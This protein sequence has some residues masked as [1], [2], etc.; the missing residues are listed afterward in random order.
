M[1]VDLQVDDY[2][3]R[4]DAEEA[5]ERKLQKLEKRLMRY[6][7]EA[8]GL[9][10]KVEKNRKRNLYRCLLELSVPGKSLVAKKELHDQRA[11]VEEAFDALMKEFSKY[12]LKANKNLYGK[13]KRPAVSYSV[14][15]ERI[16]DRELLFKEAL[17]DRLHGL[18]RLAR[19]ELLNY[20]LTG[21][22][23]PGQVLP[24]EIVDEAIVNVYQRL[25]SKT[26]RE[27]ERELMREV[28][29]VAR[30]YAREAR[31]RKGRFVPIEKET[32]PLPIEEEVVTL[33]EEI[34]YFWEPDETVKVEDEIPDP[35]AVTPEQVLEEEELQ[36][37]LYRMLSTLPEDQRTAFTL[38][39]IEC[40]TGEEVA[41]I[42]EKSPEEIAQLV[43]RATK[44][45]QQ[46]FTKAKLELEESQVRELFKKVKLLP[47]ELP[48][49]ESVEEIFVTL[50]EK[51]V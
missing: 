27:I 9:V 25:D 10:L 38:V 19:H 47:L 44:H 39:V 50:K 16:A 36:K 18:Y 32:S 17:T 6:H 2:G 41:I 49:E 14:P 48:V 1:R 7:P 40:L 28:L 12:R 29:R 4:P 46:L 33:G 23:E 20:Q 35:D 51:A 26:K 8:A 21:L 45:L 43:G 13:K 24:Q 34:L 15:A 42:M 11:V 3:L 5:L 30:N 31:E 22:M 37:L